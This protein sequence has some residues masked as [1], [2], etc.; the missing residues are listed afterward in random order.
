VVGKALRS[1]F[2]YD[3][4]TILLC[5]RW[6]REV[7]ELLFQ[8]FAL[9]TLEWRQMLIGLLGFGS[10]CQN[11]TRESQEE[12]GR[13]RKSSVSTRDPR[14]RPNT[15]S[16]RSRS[17]GQS[18]AERQ[19]RNEPKRSPVFV[20]DL[21]QLYRTMREIQYEAIYQ[22]ANE[23]DIAMEEGWCAGNECR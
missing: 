10:E 13:F 16:S 4:V 11:Q 17:P 3:G 12:R 23:L 22:V 14:R 5:W 15:H 20:V 2:R 21:R 19:S 1:A 9:A 6:V 18:A 7:E 8:A